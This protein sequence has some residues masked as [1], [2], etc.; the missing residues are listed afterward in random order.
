MSRAFL[1][2]D[3]VGDGLLPF[4]VL[5]SDRSMGKQLQLILSRHSQ[6]GRSRY[7]GKVSL[8]FK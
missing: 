5:V 1:I 8:R 3:I 2:S 4:F 6:C 7:E